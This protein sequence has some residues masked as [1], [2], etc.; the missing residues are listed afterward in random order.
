MS[1]HHTEATTIAT[2]AVPEPKHKMTKE[3]RIEIQNK[4]RAEKNA[5]REAKK[6]AKREEY[7]RNTIEITRDEFQKFKEWKRS[8]SKVR[9]NKEQYEAFLAA[10]A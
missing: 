7:E 10:N 1:E 3:E 5:E 2:A 6:A 9:V 4:K 8:I